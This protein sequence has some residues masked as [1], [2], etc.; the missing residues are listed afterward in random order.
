M[1]DLVKG[2]TKI[3]NQILSIFQ[4]NMEADERA[5]L[6]PVRGR[7]RRNR[8]CGQTFVAAPARAAGKVLECASVNLT[9]SSFV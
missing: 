6:A 8:H 3:F 4:A 9:A 1:R 7:T 2:L 5:A